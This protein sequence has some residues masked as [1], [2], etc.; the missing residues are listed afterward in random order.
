MPTIQTP[1]LSFGEQ[2]RRTVSTSVT[3]KL[4]PRHP[5]SLA[6]E[7]PSN[8]VD[9]ALYVPPYISQHHPDGS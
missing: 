5:A 8:L 1:T 3:K 2:Q 6:E 9:Y 7:K 4:T